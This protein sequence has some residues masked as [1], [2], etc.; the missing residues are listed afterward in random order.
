MKFTTEY[1]W[2]KSYLEDD[3]LWLED[4][5]SWDDT[6]DLLWSDYDLFSFLTNPFF[7]NSHLFL[8]SITKMSFL[9]V[10]FFSETD[11]LNASRELF[12]FVMWDITS[13]IG[14]NL[15]SSQF[16]FYTDYQ[17]FITVLLHHSPELTLA[18]LDYANSYWFTT[19]LSY[20]P[21]AVFDVF[22][23]SMFSVVSKLTDYAIAF[24]VFV[25]IAVIFLHVLRIT[26]WDNALESY[27]VRLENWLFN[28]AKITRI[29]FEVAI[30]AMFFV[31]FYASM[32]IAAF[33]DDSEEF[34]EF[35]NGSLFN[36]FLLLFVYFLYK[37]SIHYLAFLEASVSTGRTLSF[38]GKQFSRDILNSFAFVLRF[39][40]LMFRLNVYDANDD[41]L[42]SFYIFLG[43]FDD[44]EY[45]L[46]LF[47]SVYFSLFFDV[48]NNDDRSF[49]LE[50]E[51]DQS[52][53]LFSLYFVIWGKFSMF[54][55]F[56]LEEIGRVALA[57][58]ITYLIIFDVHAVNR[59][60]VED[61]Y[62][63]TKRFNFS[64]THKFST[65]KSINRLGKTLKKLFKNN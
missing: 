4:V 7:L 57:L 14:N 5:L 29:Q 55:F 64:I 45:F 63:S 25:W 10:L 49:I 28:F 53:D 24:F 32:M 3:A 18:L 30:K 61:K 27:L 46:D 50:D 38:T 62:F 9:D 8:D 41:L 43:D 22:N 11:E 13:F 51:M 2:L 23:D 60:Y 48:D 6:F 39:C 26:K 35:F 16:F 42:D 44:D 58:Y 15:F 34:L 65:G 33:D 47:Y 59:S 52:W 1:T 40:T 20:T 31:L 56:I 37:T 54:W 36:F 12:D 17:D 21:L 19:V